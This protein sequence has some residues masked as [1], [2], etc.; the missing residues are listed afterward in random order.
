[1]EDGFIIYR[2]TKE[3]IL[4]ASESEVRKFYGE[5]IF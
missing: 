2:N 1:M 5:E 4:A 3:N